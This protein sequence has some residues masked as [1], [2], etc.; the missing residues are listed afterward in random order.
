MG[1]M[2]ADIM[3]RGAV[4][5]LRLP[6][7]ARAV[8]APSQ[9]DS[10]RWFWGSSWSFSAD[11]TNEQVVVPFS[12]CNLVIEAGTAVIVGPTTTVSRKVLSGSGWAVAA[13][14]QPAA[15]YALVGSP[16]AFRDGF[17]EIDAGDLPA[18]AGAAFG[19]D[20]PFPVRFERARSVLAEW[21]EGQIPA[22]DEH[23]TRANRLIEVIDTVDGLDAVRDVAAAAGLPLRTAQR[24]ANEYIGFHWAI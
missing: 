8:P 21:P 3:E 12:T 23:G 7:F 9:A 4:L 5:P 14:L 24:V 22:I 15:T 20:R 18:Q 1:G 11:T 2:R 16:A 10:V 19:T 6:E 17:L 13:M